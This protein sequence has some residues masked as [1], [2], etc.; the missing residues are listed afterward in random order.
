MSVSSQVDAVTFSIVSQGL[1]AI[2]KE[3]TVSL[4]R[5]AYSTVIRE[6]SDA[7]AALLDVR[8]NI[9]AQADDMPIHLNSIAEAFRGLMTKHAVT[10]L[11]PDEILI[12]NDPFAGGQHLNDIFIFTPIHYEGRLVAFAASVG[13]HLDIGGGG[14]GS[15]NPSAVDVYAEG[16]VIPRLRLR[17]G[18]T[19]QDGL[20]GEILAANIRVPRETLGDL[21]AQLAA[22]RTGARR[23]ERMFAK[24]GV[25]TVLDCMEELL[26]YTERRTRDAVSRLTPGDYVGEDILDDDGLGNGP[27]H[28][29]VTVRV[30]SDRLVV[31][32]TGTDGQAQGY[33]NA[34]LAGT[35]AAVATALKDLLTGSSVPANEGCNRPFE[36][37]VPE[38]TILNPHAPAPVRARVNACIRAFHAVMNA[39][40]PALPEQAIGTCQDSNVLVFSEQSREGW[41]VFTEPVRGGFGAGLGNDGAV[42]CAS[43]LDNCTNT[44]IEAGELAFGFMRI[45]RYELDPDSQGFGRNCGALGAVREYEILHDGVQFASFSDRHSHAPSGLFGGRSARPTRFVLLRNG[46]ERVLPSKGAV[47]L[48]GGDRLQVRVGGGGGYGDPRER[49]PALVR[50]DLQKERISAATARDVFGFNDST[51]A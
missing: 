17:I 40:A 23:L 45:R 34:P 1:T 14:A 9:V 37:I 2:A 16:F 8:G 19:I 13:H 43:P 36:I 27:F 24:Y 4:L 42:Q 51:K 10:T 31:D 50:N 25:E 3:M 5:A 7:S 22:N 46:E 39:L 21:N 18:S 32:F 30:R 48:Q 28:I 6:A 33:V 29:R 49:D 15:L 41:R 20:F 38:G 44:P 35:K 26:D 12:T 47:S 11:E